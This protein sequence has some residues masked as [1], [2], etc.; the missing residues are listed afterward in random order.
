MAEYGFD[1]Y[2]PKFKIKPAKQQYEIK[3]RLT[4]GKVVSDTTDVII[5]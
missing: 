5:N 2:Y 3:M 4:N 1:F